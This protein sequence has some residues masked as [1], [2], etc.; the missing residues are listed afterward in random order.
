M[1]VFWNRFFLQELWEIK[2]R[3]SP[4]KSLNR[5]VLVCFIFKS[6]LITMH[7]IDTAVELFRT[8][9]NIYDWGFLQKLLTAFGS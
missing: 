6:F 9:S 4:E 5:L 1:N 3:D 8:L 7:E 2:I